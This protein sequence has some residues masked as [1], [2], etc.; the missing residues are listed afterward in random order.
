MPRR[1]ETVERKWTDEEEVNRLVVMWSAKDDDGKFTY[2]ALDVGNELHRSPNSVI[3]KVRRLG[4]PG[5]PSPIRAAGAPRDPSLKM[6]PHYGTKRAPRVT[7]PEVAKA[8]Q[9]LPTPPPAVYRGKCC[10][11]LG[12]PQIKPFRFCEE[13]LKPGTPYCPR[14]AKLA[15][16]PRQEL[17]RAA[18]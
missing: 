10:W 11:P 18:I 14:H 2:S 7:L 8:A 5:R 17:R 3:S 9:P 1:R 16:V 4:L 12:D 6:P 15:Y 13:P